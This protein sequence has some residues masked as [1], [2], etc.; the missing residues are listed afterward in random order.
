[1][2]ASGL[3]QG[4]DFFLAHSP[5]R[6]DPGNQ[7]YTTKNTNKVVGASD[8]ASLEAAILFYRETIE[9]VVPVSSAKAAEL[10]KVF[11]NTFRAVNI[12][13]VNELT[14]LCDRMGLNIW[15]VLD[16]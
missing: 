11:E 5:E 6:V 10:V 1:E 7:R 12:A 14:L 8:P 2:K 16:A 15:E 13:L 9:N 4:Q 3:K